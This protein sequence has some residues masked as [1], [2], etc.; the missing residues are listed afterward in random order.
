MNSRTQSRHEHGNGA[1]PRVKR[2]VSLISLKTCEVND[3]LTL[4]LLLSKSVLDST[5]RGA[6]S[7]HMFFGRR[8]SSFFPAQQ[9]DLC[10]ESST[11]PTR[12]L[13]QTASARECILVYQRASPN[14]AVADQ[15]SPQ[16]RN[17]R[18]ANSL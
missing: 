10:H 5:R 16:R 14:A 3:S 18:T 17:V 1:R 15:S 6:L 7:V 11:L 13:R 8:G 4:T 2:V 12:L 9:L